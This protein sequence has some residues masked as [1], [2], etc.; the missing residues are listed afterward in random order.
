M[1]EKRSLEASAAAPT[2][3]KRARLARRSLDAALPESLRVRILCHLEPAD[4]AVAARLSRTWAR[5]VDDPEVRDR[6][7]C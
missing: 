6:P 4:L 3:S 5:L 2:R 1:P 7:S